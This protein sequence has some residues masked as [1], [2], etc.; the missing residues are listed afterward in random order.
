MSLDATIN[1]AVKTVP[2]CLA[3]GYVD[4]NT[5]IARVQSTGRVR[6]LLTPGGN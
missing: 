3:A 6:V 4:L 1:E 5:G 2:E